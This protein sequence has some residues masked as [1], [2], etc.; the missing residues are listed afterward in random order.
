MLQYGVF[1][2]LG[3]LGGLATETSID[4]SA[5]QTIRWYLGVVY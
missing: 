5:A 1:F 3:G 4:L 2:P